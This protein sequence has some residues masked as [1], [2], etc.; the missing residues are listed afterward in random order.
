MPRGMHPQPRARG[1]TVSTFAYVT[2]NEVPTEVLIGPFRDST[3]PWLAAPELMEWL[4]RYRAEHNVLRVVILKAT[5][6]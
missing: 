3:V 2:Q 1:E 6:P 5:A 4:T